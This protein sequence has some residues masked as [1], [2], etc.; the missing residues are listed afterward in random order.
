MYGNE[1]DEAANIRVFIEALKRV[2]HKADIKTASKQ[3]FR[4]IMLS[5]MKGQFGWLCCDAFRQ[6]CCDVLTLPCFSMVAL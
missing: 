2:G 5:D 3:E 6:L 4:A 1:D